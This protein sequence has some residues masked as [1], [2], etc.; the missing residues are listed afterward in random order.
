MELAYSRRG[1]IRLARRFQTFMVGS[2]QVWR[3]AYAD[4]PA[5]FLDAIE[6]VDG[7]RPRRI[8]YAASFGLDDIAEYDERDRAR[9]AQLIQLFDA[10]SVRESS[11]VRICHEEF[12]VRAER[13][14]DP[15]MLLS[16]DHYRELASR[17]D[18]APTSAAGR[19]LVYRLDANDDV[20]D[21]ARELGG[22]L[23]SLPLELLP[24][25]P[26]SYREYAA[27]RD[28]TTMPSIE[29][30]LAWFASADFVVTDSFHG[31]VF[32]ILFNRPFVVYANV[33]RGASRFDTLLEV[34]G[35]RHHLVSSSADEIDRRVFAPDWG[36]VN[37]VL[38]AERA[39]A[40]SYLEGNL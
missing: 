38:D 17:A 27:D 34:F 5:H 31:C 23:G 3:A 25:W 10:V 4:I 16:A 32:S 13:H 12:G 40:M 28:G 35:L 26:A 15:T 39:R 36:A 29:K 19:L 24:A 9:A 7:D 20:S 22:R 1:R 18:V 2:D 21:I 30:W 11:G 8:S 33:S 37:R 6:S 14:L